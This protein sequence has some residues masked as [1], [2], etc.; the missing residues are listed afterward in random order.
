MMGSGCDFHA[1]K[2]RERWREVESVAYLEGAQGRTTPR[3][4]QGYCVC[5]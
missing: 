1:W 4:S 3:A 5:V 2:I